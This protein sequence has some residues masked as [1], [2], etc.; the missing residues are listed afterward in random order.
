MKNRICKLLLAIYLLPVLTLGQT[1]SGLDA[2]IKRVESGLLA[3]FTIKGEPGWTIEE[4]MKFYKVPGLSVAV[5]KDFKVVWARGYGVKDLQTKEPVTTETLFQAGSI[6]KSVNATIAMKK[7]EQGKISLDDNINDK[8]V[9]TRF[10]RCRKYST[11]QPHR[12]PRPFA[13]TSSPAR[14]F[15]IQV[16]AQPSANSL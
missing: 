5:I 11:A 6:S 1:P 15:V 4:R 14:S 12:T 7:V 9:T 2:E 13:S 3:P 10:P 8:L 16:A